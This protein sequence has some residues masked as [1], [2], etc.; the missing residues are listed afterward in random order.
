MEATDQYF[1]GDVER[2]SHGISV[3]DKLA[4]SAMIGLLSSGNFMINP[5]TINATELTKKSYEIAES[6]IK[7]SQI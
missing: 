4:E 6:M 7:Q 5:I 3:R 2:D 1:T